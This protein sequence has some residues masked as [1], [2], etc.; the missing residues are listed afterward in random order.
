MSELRRKALLAHPEWGKPTPPPQTEPIAVA[1]TKESH[2]KRDLGWFIAGGLTMFGLIRSCDAI[3]PQ[4]FP[5]PEPTPSVAP[6]PT[7]TSTIEAN[8]SPITLQTPTA[9][10]ISPPIGKE[11]DILW[12]P[13]GLESGH[14]RWIDIS[15]GV[16]SRFPDE[17]KDLQDKN[18]NALTA[19]SLAKDHIT[20]AQAYHEPP[21]TKDGGTIYSYPA[22]SVMDVINS[23]VEKNEQTDPQVSCKQVDILT[24]PNLEPTFDTF[25][26]VY[27]VATEVLAGLET[28]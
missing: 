14:F 5:P 2:W 3:T 7:A 6:L 28:K 18:T 23:C 12:E 25:G 16:M 19:L 20:P 17:P 4:P 13:K 1:T 26:P 15:N 22:D 10:A 24:R 27:N 8:P 11:P 9:V 21:K